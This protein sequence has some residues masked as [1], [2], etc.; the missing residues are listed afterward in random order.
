MS[1]SMR[2]M[3]VGSQM[4]SSELSGAESVEYIGTHGLASFAGCARA[5]LAG[6][7]ASFSIP[8]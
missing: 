6:F 1:D 4:S 7:K 2:K 5:G 8:A 3:K